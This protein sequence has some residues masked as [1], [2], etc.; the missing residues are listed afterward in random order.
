MK[1]AYL[2]LLKRLKDKNVDIVTIPEL[3]IELKIHS[4]NNFA[5]MLND[6]V[7]EESLDDIKFEIS[8][9]DKEIVMKAYEM[10]KYKIDNSITSIVLIGNE[11]EEAFKAIQKRLEL[12]DNDIIK[13]IHAVD[14]ILVNYKT[15][16]DNK[17]FLESLS[18]IHVTIIEFTEETSIVYQDNLPNLFN[19]HEAPAFENF[20][21]T[22]GYFID[23]YLMAQILH[24]IS[25]IDSECADTLLENLNSRFVLSLPNY[26]QTN[27]Y[28]LNQYTNPNL[29]D[30]IIEIV[31]SIPFERI[32][33]YDY[34]FV[35]TFL[36]D[37][38]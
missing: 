27:D 30:K 36:Y 20:V 15:Q 23:E 3:D 38:Y 19:I 16:K 2:K 18:S 29:T 13:T 4:L 1:E 37:S 14:H 33:N 10:I 9:L 6:F 7:I 35:E 11:K 17:D 12:I 34:S 28:G 24:E 5:L 8:T 22:I 21:N 26:I 31:K 25:M 32:E